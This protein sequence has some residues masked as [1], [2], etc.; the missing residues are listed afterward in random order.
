MNKVILRLKL[1]K[2]S[3]L[4][5]DIMEETIDKTDLID[6]VDDDHGIT[7][8]YFY[9]FLIVICSGSQKYEKL[10]CYQVVKPAKSWIVIICVSFRTFHQ[11]LGFANFQGRI[12]RQE[13]WRN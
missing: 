3:D 6:D 8:E 10:S 7:V 4:L 12:N 1:Q 13:N 5:H 2:I 11:V 9:T